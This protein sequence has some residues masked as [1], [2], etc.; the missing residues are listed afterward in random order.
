MAPLDSDDDEFGYDLSLEDEKLLV[1]LADATHHTDPVNAVTGT[2]S[3]P[4]ARHYDAASLS[5]SSPRRMAA[6]VGVARTKSVNTFMRRTQP[7]SAPSVISTD[8]V[9][10]PDRTCPRSLMRLC[11]TILTDLEG[12]SEQSLDRLG[13]TSGNDSAAPT[14]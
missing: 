4:D 11:R 12:S 1:F 8:D 2:T 5:G 10:Y 6:L 13:A 7:E 3:T 14:S 9:Q